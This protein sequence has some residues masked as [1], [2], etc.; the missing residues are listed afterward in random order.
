MKDFVINFDWSLFLQS[1]LEDVQIGF[2]VFRE[3]YPKS[4]DIESYKESLTLFMDEVS[5]VLKS[6][7]VICIKL[8]PDS[9][10]KRTQYFVKE[11]LDI[12]SLDLWKLN[13]VQSELGV[14]VQLRSIQ[15]IE[16]IEESNEPKTA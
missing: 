11:S 2:Q 8:I 14:Y 10:I 15:S 6:D 13:T 4:S 7:R 16:V 3:D 12:Y 9:G 5:S 1:L